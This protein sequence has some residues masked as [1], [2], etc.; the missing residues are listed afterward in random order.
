MPGL[1]LARVV[2]VNF[3]ENV[4]GLTWARAA[5]VLPVNYGERM[6]AWADFGSC[7]WCLR[8]LNAAYP[9]MVL[10]DGRP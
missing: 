7:R 2:L 10:T 9:W 5:H 8:T 6:S 3:G 4:P 1:A